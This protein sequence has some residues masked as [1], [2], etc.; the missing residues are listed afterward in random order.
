LVC[1][2]LLSVCCRP[3]EPNGK[4]KA[5]RNAHTPKRSN[6]SPKTAAFTNVVPSALVA[7]LKKA[8]EEDGGQLNRVRSEN[9]ALHGSLPK[10]RTRI[11][12]RQ[13]QPDPPISSNSSTLSAK[14]GT[15]IS[16]GG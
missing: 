1:Y 2:P 10:R 14:F 7:L 15:E 13:Q 16:F 9:A 11:L 4:R 3:E 12:L 8:D 6:L 5:A